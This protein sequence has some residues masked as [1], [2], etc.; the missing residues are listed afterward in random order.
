MSK[1]GAA[2]PNRKGMSLDI[3]NKVHKD[4]YMNRS[5]YILNKRGLI[6]PPQSKNL[7]Q[8]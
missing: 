5:Y 7:Q 4:A 3:K 1:K 6:I 2:H 8:A